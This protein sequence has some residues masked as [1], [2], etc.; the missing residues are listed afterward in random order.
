MPETKS[1]GEIVLIYTTYPDME[2]AKSIGQALVEARLAACVNIYPAVESIYRWEGVVETTREVVMIIKTRTS[3]ADEVGLFVRSRH[4]YECPCVV[5]LPVAGGA[6]E[7][8]AWI[9]SGVSV[10]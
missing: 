7:Y 1:E 9:M 5:V 6:A 2:S 10:Q 3:V 4:R 8:L